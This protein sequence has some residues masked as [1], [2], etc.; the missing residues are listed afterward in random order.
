MLVKDVIIF[1]YYDLINIFKI[2][3]KLSLNNI[4]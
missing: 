3:D 4:N 1:N 2:L